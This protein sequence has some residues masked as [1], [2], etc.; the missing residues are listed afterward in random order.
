MPSRPASSSRPMK[1]EMYVA[2]ALAASSAWL[3]LKHSVT[4]TGVPS[5]VRALQALRPSQVSGTFTVTLPAIL[6]SRRPSLSMPSKSV[7]ATSAETGP[8]TTAQISR[9]VSLKS[10]PVLATSEGLV[11][12]P[13]SRPV[14][15]SSRISLTSAVSTKNFMA[16]LSF[17]PFS[18]HRWRITGPGYW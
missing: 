11:V 16:R 6:A 13:S 4:L 7:A 15:A 17:L 2:P 1:G 9:T 10:L 5:L 14:S 8:S 18:L 12:T 3:A